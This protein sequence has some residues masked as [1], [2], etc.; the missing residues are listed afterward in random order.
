MCYSSIY[1]YKNDPLKNNESPK[2]H[3]D[4]IEHFFHN[5]KINHIFEFTKYLKKYLLIYILLC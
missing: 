5:T 3:S 4:V 2:Y 1:E